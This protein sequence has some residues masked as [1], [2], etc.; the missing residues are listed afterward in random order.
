MR[1]R[2]KMVVGNTDKYAMHRTK[3]GSIPLTFHLRQEILCEIKLRSDSTDRL[4]HEWIEIVGIRDFD[5]GK[6]A[7]E[8]RLAGFSEKF[9]CMTEAQNG[10]LFVCPAVKTTDRY[11]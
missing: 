4:E 9:P 8:N 7:C 2:E 11:A 3:I 5:G 6:E 1:V 10:E